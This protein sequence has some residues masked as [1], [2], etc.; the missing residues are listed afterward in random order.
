M[1][2]NDEKVFFL[3]GSHLGTNQR[4]PTCNI[5]FQNK[6]LISK[7]LL[8]WKE[9]VVFANKTDLEPKSCL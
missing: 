9:I 2:Q 5:I 1:N 6:K 8:D 4:N 3:K 7:E